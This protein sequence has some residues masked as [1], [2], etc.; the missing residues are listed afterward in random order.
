MKILVIS[1]SL[2]PSGGS[3]GV[4][5]ELAKSYSS[6]SKSAIL[7]FSKDRSQYLRE[8]VKIYTLPTVKNSFLYYYT[9]GRKEIK[10][11]LNNYKPDLI[12][13][14][15]FPNILSYVS[16]YYDG[17]KLLTLHNSPYS[18]YNR[19]YYFKY[20]ERFLLR[21]LKNFNLISTPSK[22][23]QKYFTERFKLDV[24]KISN[25]VNKKNFN[26]IITLKDH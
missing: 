22:R 1:N 24:K 12:H 26:F 10:K 6:H 16:L 3:E 9:F 20:K 23:M 11:I 7:V 4:A 13:I 25:G 19:S 14:H 8:G 18:D 15:N 5:W 2:P 21:S 17:F